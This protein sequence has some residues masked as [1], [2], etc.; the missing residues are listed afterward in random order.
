MKNYK[1]KLECLLEWRKDRPA[2]QKSKLICSDN[3]EKGGIDRVYITDK[4]GV[5]ISDLKIG[6]LSDDN[7][8]C[9]GTPKGLN[10]TF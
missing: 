8:F 2:L 7:L 1:Q 10:V 4:D 5:F 3:I 6:K 9:V